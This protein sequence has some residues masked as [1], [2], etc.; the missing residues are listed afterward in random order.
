MNKYSFIVLAILL[1]NTCLASAQNIVNPNGWNVFY[2]A[3]GVKSSE[4]TM[5]ESK[6]DGYWKTYYENGKLKS[7]GNR[8]D[9]ALDSTWIFYTD[10]GD[11]LEVIN[12]MTGIKHGEHSIYQAGNPKDSLINNTVLSSELFLRGTQEGKSYYYYPSGKLKEVVNYEDGRKT[13]ISKMFSEDGRLI[14]MTRYRNNFVVEREVI[15]QY[16]RNKQK[17]GVWKEFYPNDRIKAEMYY[18]NDKLT[19]YYR[20]Y[21]KSGRL[22]KIIRY[23][24]GEVL[25]EED[26]PENEQ[27][28]IK[29]EIGV[30][31]KVKSTGSYRN[32]KP[33]GMHREFDDNGKLV[34]AKVY[35]E[36][37][38]LDGAGM[39]DST[40]KRQGAWKHYF[41]TGEVQSAGNYTNDIKTGN[42]TFFY[43]SGVVEQKGNYKTGKPEGQWTWYYDNGKVE[44]EEVFVRGLPEGMFIE[45]SPTGDTLT[46]G[47]YIE[48]EKEGVWYYNVGDHT[49]IGE[50]KRSL[51]EG[52]WK[53]YF[54]DGTLKSEGK[55]TQDQPV[56]EHLFYYE[57]GK[58]QKEAYY[59]K[60]KKEK[61]WKF[62]DEDGYLRITIYYKNDQ[63]MKI[64]GAKI[65]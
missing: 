22:S 24:D 52:V 3:N 26:I 28:E 8:K 56:G 2:F 63:E 51:R 55:Y 25:V 20:E 47:E 64:D 54:P 61:S 17:Q 42:W 5:R 21:D 32:N 19:G 7:E 18:S 59:S 33:V 65:N 62:Y 44:R 43:P 40:I 15:N 41:E 27:L 49:E 50:Y 23:R 9:F 4:G 53:S 12:Y 36:F 38:V 58:L 37:N 29:Q 39:V 48:G 46:K 57:N 31:G 45:Y 30:N 6:P 35:N 14:S 60:G 10:K 1:I 11:T 34:I 16:D 13:G